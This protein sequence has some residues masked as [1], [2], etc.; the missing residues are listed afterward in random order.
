MAVFIPALGLRTGWGTE[1]LGVRQVG[2]VAA[3][4]SYEHLYILLG[5]C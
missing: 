4:V 3:L 5:G 1:D 2:H